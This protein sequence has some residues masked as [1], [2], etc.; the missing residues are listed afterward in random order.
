MSKEYIIN[1]EKF[2]E[3]LSRYFV[4]ETRRNLTYQLIA[5]DAIEKKEVITKEQ[6]EQAK[7][8]IA[9]QR[10]CEDYSMLT[11]VHL[12]DVFAVLD[13]LIKGDN[14]ERKNN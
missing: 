6:L 2:N 10:F 1:I 7:K 12:G 13:E 11:Q 3:F 14:D 9:E 8:D 5:S 4:D